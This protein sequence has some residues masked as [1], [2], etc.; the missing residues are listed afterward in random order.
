M[1]LLDHF[2]RP[3][4]HVGW[5]RHADLLGGVQVDHQFELCRLFNGKIGG[6]GTFKDFV[7]V[8]GYAPVAVGQVRPVVHEPTKG[9][10]RVGRP[11]SP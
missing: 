7:H 2:I 1:A 10:R 8:G 11:D 4:Q 6:L 9:I 5:N 3:R